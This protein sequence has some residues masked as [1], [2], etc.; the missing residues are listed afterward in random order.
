MLKHSTPTMEVCITDNYDERK[1]NKG[2]L[3]FI[4]YVRIQMKFSKLLH[5][6][7][8][9]NTLNELPKKDENEIYGNFRW[10][11]KQSAVVGRN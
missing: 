2:K 7:L 1:E 4:L 11:C 10:L 5:N 6:Y 3:F 9:P 8:F